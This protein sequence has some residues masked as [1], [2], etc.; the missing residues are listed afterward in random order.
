[1]FLRGK[2]VVNLA[3]KIIY[4]DL[5]VSGSDR[6]CY[7][8]NGANTTGPDGEGGAQTQCYNREQLTTDISDLNTY[9]KVALYE[10]LQDLLQN[11]Q[12]A[13]T[14]METAVT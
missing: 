12:A 4:R 3:V 14:H 2:V 11:Q 5:P 1:M 7:D 6:Q 8:D 13:A 10:L 9:Q